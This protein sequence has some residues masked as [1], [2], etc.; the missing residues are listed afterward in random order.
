MKKTKDSWLV[1]SLA[2][3]IYI[4]IYI[5]YTPN[6]GS[7]ITLFDREREQGRFRES[8]EGARGRS[9]GAPGEQRGSTGE[10]RGSTGEH[11]GAASEQGGRSK[12]A[13][14]LAPQ[15]PDLAAPYPATAAPVVYPTSVA[16]LSRLLPRILQHRRLLASSC[17][18][19]M[20]IDGGP[21]ARD[22]WVGFQKLSLQDNFSMMIK[23][24]AKYSLG[25]NIIARR[26]LLI[27]FHP[28]CL[29]ICPLI[30]WL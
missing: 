16:W 19:E 13:K 30:P 23:L 26:F 17:A 11:G 12:R 22:H 6:L 5:I 20:L 3:K 28:R 21:I 29:P 24:S 18:N 15:E 27:L 7:E 8:S 10:Q 4:Y 9:K 25:H 14:V 1:T 2:K